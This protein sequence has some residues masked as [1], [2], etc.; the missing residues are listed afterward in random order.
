MPVKEEM[1]ASG[2]EISLAWNLNRIGIGFSLLQKNDKKRTACRFGGAL[3]ASRAV[4]DIF[5][6]GAK[7]SQSLAMPPKSSD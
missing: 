6:R 4:S 7:A 2:I 5:S 3:F 1:D